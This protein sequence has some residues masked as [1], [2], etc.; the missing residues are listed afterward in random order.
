MLPD[1]WLGQGIEVHDAPTHHG[2]LSFAVRWHGDRPALLWE[3]TPHA[4]ARRAG[5]AHRA[6]ARPDVV[7]DRAAGGEALDPR[8]LGP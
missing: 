7:V 1:A 3:L 2:V 6:R 8:R 4:D 5:A